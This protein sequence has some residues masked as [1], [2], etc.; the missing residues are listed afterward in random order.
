MYA[1]IRSTLSF[2]SRTCR[3]FLA[4]ELGTRLLE[5]IRLGPIPLRS[6]IGDCEAILSVP[7]QV[8]RSDFFCDSREAV[9][10]T[11]LRLSFVPPTVHVPPFA[12]ELSGSFLKSASNANLPV[13]PVQDTLGRTAT[14]CAARSRSRCT[15]A[16]ETA[17]ILE[18][19]EL[20]SAFVGLTVCGIALDTARTPLLLVR[21]LGDASFALSGVGTGAGAV[22]AISGFCTSTA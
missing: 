1:R 10:W 7:Y 3:S 2:K 11:Y 5:S 18:A 16:A 13:W 20:L 19:I 6:I 12:C 15:S 21:L 14:D 8:E 4:R 22:G 17:T 9:A